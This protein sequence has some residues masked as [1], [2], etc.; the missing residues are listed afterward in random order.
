M[1]VAEPSAPGWLE[2]RANKG[3][4]GAQRVL[5]ALTGSVLDRSSE[6]MSCL[7]SGNCMLQNAVSQF[8]ALY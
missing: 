1:I 7:I 2:C 6:V 5:L 3:A 4:A 8:C